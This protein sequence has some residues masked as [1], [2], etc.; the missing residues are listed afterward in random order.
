MPAV[1]FLDTRDVAIVCWTV[2]SKFSEEVLLG[3]QEKE[4]PSSET[5]TVSPPW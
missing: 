4:A 5:R 3:S 1:S 2:L